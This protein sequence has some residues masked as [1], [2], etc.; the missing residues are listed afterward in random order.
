M[1]TFSIAE[2]LSDIQASNLLPFPEKTLGQELQALAEEL[3]EI[4]NRM[5]A[6]QSLL[7]GLAVI[8][9]AEVDPERGVFHPR[10]RRKRG[11]LT[12][13]CRSALGSA[14]GQLPVSEICSRINESSPEVLLGHRKPMASV[15]S[16]LRNMQRHREVVRGE[17]NGKSVWRLSQTPVEEFSE[18]CFRA[19]AC[20]Q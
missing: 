14:P 19:P 17:D 9:P 7:R 4:E 13:A 20:F 3:R 16:V 1:G 11:A 12:A 10:P 15:M 2:H 5:A 8:Y 6:I 18:I